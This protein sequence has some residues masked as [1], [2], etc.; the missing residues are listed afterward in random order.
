MI[1]YCYFLHENETS[2][3]RKKKVFDNTNTLRCS[4]FTAYEIYCLR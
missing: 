1:S 3:Q 2:T 4:F